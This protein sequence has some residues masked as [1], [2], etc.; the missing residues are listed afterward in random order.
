M[1]VFNKPELA[2]QLKLGIIDIEEGPMIMIDI[3]NIP[4]NMSINGFLEHIKD[5]GITI[6][7]K[8]NE[9]D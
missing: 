2:E 1:K 7:D 6:V 5:L 9:I 8:R 3:S 4:E